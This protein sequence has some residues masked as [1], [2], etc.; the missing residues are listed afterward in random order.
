MSGFLDV[1]RQF[2]AHLRDPRRPAPRGIEARRLD[3]Y[4]RLFYG[5]V[6]GFLATAFPVLRRITPD[7]RWH[8]R[9]R[10][11]FVR[12]RSSD[13]LF[14]H[15]A[16]EFLAYLERRRPG[17]DDPPFLRELAHHEWVELALS[18]D[19]RE[20]AAVSAD[21]EGD[22]LAGVPVLSPLAWPHHYRYAVHRIGPDFRPRNAEPQGVHLVAWR[23]R[24]DQVRFMEANVVTARL[25][26]LMAAGRSIGRALLA[27]IAR[28]LGHQQPELVIAQGGAI[29]KD[30]A[31]RD[32]V[33]GTKPVKNKR[34]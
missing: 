28:E 17:R 5:N 33:L 30:L 1:Q 29:L 27:R 12:H 6:E 9:V 15:I 18:Y 8:A 31:G 13:P 20:L 19:V 32:I 2:A 3:L 16:R 24:A 25:L 10:D 14:Q 4:A 11:F 7:S 23:N 34:R 26:Q 22:L 21:P